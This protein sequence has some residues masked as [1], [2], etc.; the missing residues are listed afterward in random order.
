MPESK[1]IREVRLLPGLFKD[2]MEVNRFP[3][4]RFEMK[5]LYEIQDEKYTVYYTVQEDE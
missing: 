3:G 1:T 5:P 2:R 4:G